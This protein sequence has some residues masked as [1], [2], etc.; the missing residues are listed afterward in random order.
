VA[1]SFSALAKGL[2]GV[3]S[4]K[5]LSVFFIPLAFVPAFAS[6]IR[7]CQQVTCLRYIDKNDEAHA[8]NAGFQSYLHH[9]LMEHSSINDI[10]LSVDVSLFQGVCS[11]LATLPN[12]RSC[13]LRG[14]YDDASAVHIL[15]DGATEALCQ[16]LSSSELYTFTIMQIGFGEESAERVGNALVTSSIRFFDIDTAHSSNVVAAIFRNSRKWKITHLA[17][18]LAKW[19]ETIEDCLSSYVTEN[20]SL[21][22]VSVRLSGGQVNSFKADSLLAA[23][24]C[25]KRGHVQL[26]VDPRDAVD[27]DWDRRLEHVLAMNETREAVKHLFDTIEGETSLAVLHLSHL[28]QALLGMNQSML[29]DF[30]RRNE[31]HLQEL[32]RRLCPQENDDEQNEDDNLAVL[33]RPNRKRPASSISSDE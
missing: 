28:A 18:T 21:K 29:L 22:A 24:D 9:C 33:E 11:I 20:Y 8:T 7:E 26:F 23:I 32:L 5:S 15:S 12:L 16:L 13:F 19:N 3:Q 31:W 10:T 6:F 14:P 17:I 27:D 2:G 1:G 4:L 25:P 30:L